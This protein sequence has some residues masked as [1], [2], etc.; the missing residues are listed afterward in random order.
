H[1]KVRLEPCAEDERGLLVQELR[2]S[3]L[4]L[5]MQVERAVQEPAPRAAAA[6]GPQRGLG[7]LDHLRVMRQPEVVVG[8]DHDLTLTVDDHFGVVGCLDRYEVRVYSGGLELPGL[9]EPVTLF[10]QT[11]PLSRAQEDDA[12]AIPRSCTTARSRAILGRGEC[13]S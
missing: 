9:G 1:A 4:Q 7:R 3:L 12:R 10:E 5:L 13:A 11:H 6:V 8:T 2:Q